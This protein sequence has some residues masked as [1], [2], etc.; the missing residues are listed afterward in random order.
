MRLDDI[1]NEEARLLASET[2]FLAPG[3]YVLACLRRQ[4]V[5][6]MGLPFFNR[7]CGRRVY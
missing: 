4:P 2:F 7:R 6:D 3:E 1:G 5:R